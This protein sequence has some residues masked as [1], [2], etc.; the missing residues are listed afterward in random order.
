MVKEGFMGEEAVFDLSLKKWIGSGLSETK[1]ESCPEER[2]ESHSMRRRG[3][4]VKCAQRF[5]AGAVW[6]GQIVTP[7]F[8]HCLV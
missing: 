2:E 1:E 4:P 8:S 6:L 7:D 3:G 5:C